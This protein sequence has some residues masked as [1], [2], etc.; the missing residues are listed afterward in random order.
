MFLQSCLDITP[1]QSL[2]LWHLWD[3][4]L[5]ELNF[6]LAEKLAL[7]EHLTVTITRAQRTEAAYLE[8]CEHSK[9]LAPETDRL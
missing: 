7:E 5:D 3:T 4:S 1:S 9:A 2:R 8:A 6:L